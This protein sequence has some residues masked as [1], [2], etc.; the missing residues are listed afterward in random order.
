M[1]VN[2]DNP[3]QALVSIIQLPGQVITL[4]ANFLIPPYR[5]RITNRKMSFNNF[6]EI[7]LDPIFNVFSK[8]AIHEAV[9]EE[10]VNSSIKRYIDAKL[11]SNPPRII[12]H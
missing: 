6:Q 7:W 1:R 12:L 4:D 8:L 11:D 2:L 3:N 9:Y 10:L 5:R